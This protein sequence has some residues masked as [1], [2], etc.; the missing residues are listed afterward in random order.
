MKKNLKK[1]ALTA[2]IIWG[3]TMF[4]MTLANIYFGYGRAFLE[5]IASIYPGY[6]LTL[7]GSV[8]GL[9]YGFTD[10]FVGLYII[11]WVYKR[12]GGK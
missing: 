5:A 7:T 4:M 2:G 3:G 6:T 11:A 9:I 10:A 12:L 1:V 8:I